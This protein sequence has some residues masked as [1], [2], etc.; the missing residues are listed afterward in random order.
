MYFV[1][2][3]SPAAAAAKSL[4]LGPTLCDPH[5]RQ[6]TRLPRPWDSLGKNTEV[7]C[8]FLLQCM[9][10]KV[11][12]KLLSHVW[13]LATPWTAAYQ[14]PLS[15]GF[16]RREYWSG[17]PLPSPPFSWVLPKYKSQV[18][19]I[20]GFPGG[21]SDKERSCPCRRL[22]RCGFNPWIRNIPWRGVWQPTLVFLPGESHGQKSLAGYRPGSK[23]QTLLSMHAA[24]K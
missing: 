18:L 23:S 5:R 13:L 1:K 15:M 8:H 22:K 7:G 20:L 21:A 4:Q 14:A 24:H 12:V 19:V 16:S 10:G 3:L 11:K 2:A 6:P 9:K 17:L